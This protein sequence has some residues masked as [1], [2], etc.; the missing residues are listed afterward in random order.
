M[1]N[2]VRNSNSTDFDAYVKYLERMNQ[3]DPVT[4][5]KMQGLLDKVHDMSFSNVVNLANNNNGLPGLAANAEL[6]LRLATNTF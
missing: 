5:S 6:L 1:N 3:A 2:N 4:A